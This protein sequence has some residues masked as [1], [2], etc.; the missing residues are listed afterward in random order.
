MFRSLSDF[1]HFPMYFNVLGSLIG[2]GWTDLRR[3]IWSH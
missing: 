3:F 2:G 1:S